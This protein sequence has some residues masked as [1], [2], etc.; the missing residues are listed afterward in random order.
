MR[1]IIYSTF[2]LVHISMQHEPRTRKVVSD[3]SDGVFNVLFDD[4][5]IQKK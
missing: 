2:S 3:G 4:D 5:H 1:I